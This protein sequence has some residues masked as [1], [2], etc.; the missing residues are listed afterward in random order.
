[1]P[2]QRHCKSL[3][4][5]YKTGRGKNLFNAQQAQRRRG[6][7]ARPQAQENSVRFIAGRCKK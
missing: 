3:R 4:Q 6:Q 7:Q 1:M 5:N 2:F